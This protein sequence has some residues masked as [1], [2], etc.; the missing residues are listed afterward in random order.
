MTTV[1]D[2]WCKPE[3]ERLLFT[4]KV[5]ID[6]TQGQFRGHVHTNFEP[7]SLRQYA[8]H[9]GKEALYKSFIC[10]LVLSRL[11]PCNTQKEYLVPFSELQFPQKLAK[12]LKSQEKSYL[13]R[14]RLLPVEEVQTQFF[15]ERSAHL[16][17]AFSTLKGL[18]NYYS[19]DSSSSSE[20]D[21]ATDSLLMSMM[22]IYASNC[23]SCLQQNSVCQLLKLIRDDI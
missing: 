3:V 19:R 15:K 21:D 14:V 10:R 7:Y 18:S 16:W 9:K 12:R 20:E 1:A 2:G 23:R 5:D 6:E 13:V 17:P 8:I 11:Q 22:G 4:I